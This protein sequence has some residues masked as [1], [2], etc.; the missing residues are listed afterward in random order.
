[1][2]NLIPHYLWTPLIGA[3]SIV[4]LAAG[5]YVLGFIVEIIYQRKIPKDRSFGNICISGA[6]I[7]LLVISG[8][9]MCWGVGILV[10]DIFLR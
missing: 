10:T 3:V 5:V 8:I 9:I 4:A 6:A 1:M 7:C 2:I